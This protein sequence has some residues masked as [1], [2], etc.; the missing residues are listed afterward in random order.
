MKFKILLPLLLLVFLPAAGFA[1]KNVDRLLFPGRYAAKKEK[2]S[3]YIVALER[4]GKHVS[5]FTVRLNT[6]NRDTKSFSCREVKLYT[7]RFRGD[8]AEKK[9]FSCN[10]LVEGMRVQIVKSDSKVKEVI[11][12]PA[13]GKDL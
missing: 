13:V 4:H 3:G 5:A 2:I 9:K 6:M 8:L 12:I 10:D 7:Y 1:Q 11:V